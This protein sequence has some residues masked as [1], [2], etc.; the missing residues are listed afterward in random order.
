[1]LE[2]TAPDFDR[3]A[4]QNLRPLLESEEVLLWAGRPHYDLLGFESPAAI[5]VVTLLCL[6]LVLWEVVGSFAAR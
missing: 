5:V 3:S 6:L 1:M 4:V 2:S